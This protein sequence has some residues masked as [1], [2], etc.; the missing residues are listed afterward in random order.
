MDPG[1]L[2][3]INNYG[4]LTVDSSNGDTTIEATFN[5][6]NYAAFQAGDTILAGGGTLR[7]TM[8]IDGGSRVILQRGTFNAQGLIPD[9][10]TGILVVGN[11]DDATLQVSQVEL[12]RS[13]VVLCLGGTISGP[14]T[15]TVTNEF[16]WSGG[17]I[18]DL[19]TATNVANLSGQLQL[20]GTLALTG[21]TTLD[22]AIIDGSGLLQENAGDVTVLDANTV[23]N[24]N[25][26]GGTLT[27]PGTLE[28]DGTM[29]WLAGSWVA[30]GVLNVDTGAILNI[31]LSDS[32]SMAGWAVNI[33]GIVNWY[34]GD[35]DATGSVLN[36]A[37]GG[38]F[39]INAATYV[40]MH[41]WTINNDGNTNWIAG[42]ID[43]ENCTFDNYGTFN[44][45][46]SST[47]H[48]L[49]ADNPSTI[50]NLGLLVSTAGTPESPT[51][52]EPFYINAGTT[53]V[54]AAL[55]LTGG[56]T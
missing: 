53:D 14:G 44:G 29:N 49:S 21:T 17:T 13:N 25:M 22:R 30:G 10:T 43:S 7:G 27:G 15:L 56:E 50:N 5:S 6:T 54:E 26:N 8:N 38:I 12:R 34:S 2:S 37:A 48:D 18:S 52:I 1:N 20:D 39:N 16:D 32:V 55:E 19:V 3:Q 11:D 40:T 28:I 36:I 45:S 47:W 51:L 31:T 46:S 9:S 33:D 23:R 35:I 41:N 24:F 4:S 42:E